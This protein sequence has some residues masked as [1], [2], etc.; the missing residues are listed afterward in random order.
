MRSSR[1]EMARLGIRLLGFAGL[2]L[3]LG[4]LFFRFV[5]PAGD[6][7]YQ[8]LDQQFFVKHYDTQKAVDGQYAFDRLSKERPRWHINSAGYNCLREYEAPY[9]GRKP[10]VTVIGDSYVQGFHVGVT[11]TVTADL[12]Q[13]FGD[14]VDVYTMG[15]T[16]AP[17]SQFWSVAR[18]AHARYAP[19]LLVFLVS[20]SDLDFSIANYHRDRQ[21]LQ[22]ERQDNEFRQLPATQPF[23]SSRLR[24]LLKN[25]A[26][27][28][29][30]TFNAKVEITQGLRRATPVTVTKERDEDLFARSAAYIV[31]SM[32]EE[33]P[34]TPM[35]FMIHPAVADLQAGKPPH[36][37][38]IR[39]W[40]EDAVAEHPQ[41]RVLD[42]G[43]AFASQYALDSQRF[44][45]PGEG[46]W[47][48]HAHN[49]CARTLADFL[50][51]EGL[52]DDLMT[53][54][55]QSSAVLASPR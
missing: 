36:V 43:P 50:R 45:F 4:E 6:A 32:C 33:F 20:D 47:N 42:L 2:A 44:D 5:I 16:A 11:R 35:V 37:P 3:L 15:E 39:R 28:R 30:V 38:V 1:R 22:V 40:L 41:A 25:S 24:R 9:P 19:D 23:R 48:A 10:V 54:A 26:I 17:L 12:Q 52:W 31:R 18:C 53:L 13:L 27:I 46:H 7:P 34:A 29:Y 55:N 21:F 8:V 14:A 51:V 49:L